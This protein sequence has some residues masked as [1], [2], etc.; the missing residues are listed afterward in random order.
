MNGEAKI[1][2]SHRSRTAIIYVRQSTMVQVR[3]HTESTTRQYALAGEAE[4]LGWPAEAV[5]VIDADLGV[6][7]RYGSDRGGFRD[8]VARVCLGEV[9]AVFGL[10][11]SRL[12]RS[13][14][15]FTRL[16]ELARLTDTLVID[17]GRMVL[18]RWW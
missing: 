9:G 18:A 15:E 11:V 13:S 3:D 4:R 7:G 2:A 10:E 5:E 6:S 8:I 1:T 17:T 14:A 12:A 16:L